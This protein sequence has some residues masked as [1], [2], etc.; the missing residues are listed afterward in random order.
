MLRTTTGK[1]HIKG[2]AVGLSPN[3]STR[4]GQARSNAASVLV[5]YFGSIAGRLR[6]GVDCVCGQHGFQIADRRSFVSLGCSGLSY[7]TVLGRPRGL[8]KS[9]RLQSLIGRNNGSGCVNR[10]TYGVTAVAEIADMAWPIG[11]VVSMYG[12]E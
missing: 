9:L 11:V 10:R 5:V 6:S 8:T 4:I 12:S 2:S 1:G 3:P 7:D